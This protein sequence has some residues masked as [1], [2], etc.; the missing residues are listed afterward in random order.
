MWFIR[1]DP[2]S[3]DRLHPGLDS[4]PPPGGAIGTN[5]TAADLFAFQAHL[6]CTQVK[7]VVNAA[8]SSNSLDKAPALSARPSRAPP[9]LSARLSPARSEVGAVLRFL[10]STFV[11]VCC[12]LGRAVEKVFLG[13]LIRQ[14]ICAKPSCCMCYSFC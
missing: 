6:Q 8:R 9:A 2:F 12:S 3:G 7:V 10:V 11:C 5:V 14:H 1:L 4:A 13:A